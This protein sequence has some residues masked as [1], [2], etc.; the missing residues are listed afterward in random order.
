MN[1]KS[2][3]GETFFFHRWKIYLPSVKD[4]SIVVKD[5]LT[6]YFNQRAESRISIFAIVRIE[7]QKENM[8]RHIE[9]KRESTSA[10]NAGSST[11]VGS[12]WWKDQKPY[13][14]GRATTWDGSGSARRV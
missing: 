11:R 3:I 4:L 10:C 12:M 9:I 1:D 2:F 8:M 7:I 14:G 13:G 5:L 6:F